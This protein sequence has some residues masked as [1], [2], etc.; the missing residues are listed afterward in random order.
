MYNVCPLFV[1]CC[2]SSEDE[3]SE[4]EEEPSTVYGNIR[5]EEIPSVP[6]NNFLSRDRRDSDM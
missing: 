3:V 2:F 5:P 1:S 4:K 6:S